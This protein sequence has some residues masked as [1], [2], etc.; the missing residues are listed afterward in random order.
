MPTVNPTV[1]PILK[2]VR[3]NVLERLK[4]FK[5]KKYAMVKK[6]IKA[7]FVKEYKSK[8]QQ[9]KTNPVVAVGRD[10]PP[11]VG[12]V[13][14][15]AQD[16]PKLVEQ[17]QEMNLLG[18]EANEIFL[19]VQQDAVTQA[20]KQ[21]QPFFEEKGE[22]EISASKHGSNVNELAQSFWDALAE[23]KDHS[24]ESYKQALATMRAFKKKHYEHLQATNPQEMMAYEN[25]LDIFDNYVTA[26]Q[27]QKKQIRG[28]SK[29]TCA[30]TSFWQQVAQKIELWQ[31]CH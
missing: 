16:G 6:E 31:K 21:I 20:K 28:W 24:T 12:A 15:M 7:F 14:D 27:A 4:D 13:R 2:Q 3:T 29:K 9:Y 11:L 19:Q 18:K 23:Q 17:F 8:V 30:G 26:K 5:S 1:K 10:L 25:L 22:S